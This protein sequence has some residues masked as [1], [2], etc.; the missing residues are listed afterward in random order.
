MSRYETAKYT[1]LQP[2]GTARQ[3]SFVMG[4]KSVIT[5]PSPGIELEA[6]GVHE[7]S[8]LAWSGAG[9]VQAVEVS[10]DGGTTWSR[11]R[12]EAPVL[13]ACLTR[14][15]LSW[16]WDGRR[17]VILSRVRDEVGNRQ[18]SRAEL[19]SSQGEH[20]YYHYNAVV[21]WEVT[22]FGEVRHVYL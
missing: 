15:R 22:E 11:A 7:I 21:S 13:P 6:P 12:L 5:Y 16:R 19:I 2:D 1:D 20:P 14:F 17:A 3:F 4:A 9:R 10:T 8:G 18:P